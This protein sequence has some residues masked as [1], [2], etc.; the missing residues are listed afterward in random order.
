MVC[1]DYIEWLV[2]IKS[3]H[4]P[5]VSGRFKFLLPFIKAVP[6]R[7]DCPPTA[8]SPRLETLGYLTQSSVLISA[9]NREAQVVRSCLQPQA[10][11]LYEAFW[12]RLERYFTLL[13]FLNSPQSCF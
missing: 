13:H 3:A 10:P 12:R 1:G 6:P 7:R 5:L 11:C 8:F 9:E 2:E 4:Q